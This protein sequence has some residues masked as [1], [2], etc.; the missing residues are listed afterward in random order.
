MDFE[1]LR[2]EKYIHKNKGHQKLGEK[3]RRKKLRY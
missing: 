3:R 1:D 2:K